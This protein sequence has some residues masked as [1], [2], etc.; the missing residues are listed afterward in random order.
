MR[1]VRVV[2]HLQRQCVAGQPVVTHE[3]QV[4]PGDIVV[5]D[6][7]PTLLEQRDLGVDI[8]GG[9]GEFGI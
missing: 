3:A 5:G 1:T 4:V 2:I 8:D 9:F 6:R 7:Q